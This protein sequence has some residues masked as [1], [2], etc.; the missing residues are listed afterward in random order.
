EPLSSGDF[1]GR[2]MSQIAPAAAR[3]APE[4]RKDPAAYR[5]R[6][7]FASVE[8]SLNNLMTFPDVRSLVEQGALRLHGAFFSVADGRLLV[9]NPGTGAFEAEAGEPAAALSGARR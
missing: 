9:R 8:L 3:I 1:I 5:R 2:W 6:L 7:E 4:E